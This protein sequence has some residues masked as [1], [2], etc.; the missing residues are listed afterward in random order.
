MEKIAIIGAGT[1]GH[2]FAMLFA[3]AGHPVRLNDT[4]Q[5]ILSR[6]QK[7]ISANL[8][9]LAEVGLFDLEE[10]PAVEARIEYTTDLARA[11]AGAD[12]VIEAIFEDVEAKKE[13]FRELDRLAPPEAVLASKHLLSGHIPVRGN[14][15]AGQNRH[16][17]LVR[18]T[19]HRPPGGDSSW[20]PDLAGDRVLC[21]GNSGPAGQDHRSPQ[22]VPA[23]FHSQPFAR[24]PSTWRC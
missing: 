7:L 3:Q 13:L 23:R 17:P 19:A 12:L 2:C 9:T 18:P 24:W 11:A 10:R 14:R 22:K 21:Q 16:N 4:S 8:E 15:A 5:E 1:M 20:S 6:A